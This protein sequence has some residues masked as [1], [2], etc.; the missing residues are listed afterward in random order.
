MGAPGITA[1][2]GVCL[3]ESHISASMIVFAFAKMTMWHSHW[4]R[5][6]NESMVGTKVDTQLIAQ[7]SLFCF[8]ARNIRERIRFFRLVWV[9]R[10]G[11]REGCT[12][13]KFSLGTGFLPLTHLMEG[14]RQQITRFLCQ[15][16]TTDIVPHTAYST[17]QNA[18][19]VLSVFLLL[20]QVQGQMVYAKTDSTS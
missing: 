15:A 7:L 5:A 12:E 18:A 14:T 13:V 3:P 20:C 10:V 4:G 19:W 8:L 1:R 9:I 2:M 11:G 16:G 17:S 6:G